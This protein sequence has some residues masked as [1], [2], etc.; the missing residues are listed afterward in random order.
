M[1]HG[2]RT[3]HDSVNYREDRRVRAHAQ[4][5]SE[6][7]NGSESRILQQH[8]Q[9]VTHIIGNVSQP[10]PSPNVS[11]DLLHQLHVSKFPP[12]RVLRFFLL[13]TSLRTLSRRH[14]QMA[15]HFLLQLFL[16]LPLAKESTQPAHRDSPSPPTSNFCFPFSNSYSYLSATIGSTFIALRAGM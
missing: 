8:S 3:Q 7:R 4:R 15:P 14:L 2:K 6:N 11:R 10:R 16:P 1:P 9:S 13:L 12:R 5:K